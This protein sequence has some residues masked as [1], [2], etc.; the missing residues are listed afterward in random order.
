M[1]R[2]WKET[3]FGL[4]VDLHS[5]RYILMPATAPKRSR[6][7][8]SIKVEESYRRRATFTKAPCCTPSPKT[9]PVQEQTEDRRREAVVHGWTGL[10]TIL[11]ERP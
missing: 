10:V 4:A 2:G 9:T 11:D 3:I 5:T 1:P 6:L 7:F 8:I